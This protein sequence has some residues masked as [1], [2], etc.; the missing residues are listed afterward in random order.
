MT[1]PESA[2]YIYHNKGRFHFGHMAFYTQ[3]GSLVEI[4]YE[5]SIEDLK[6]NLLEAALGEKIHSPLEIIDSIPKDFEKTFQ[7][8]GYKSWIKFTKESASI[9]I[10]VYKN[11]SLIGIGPRGT[12]RGFIYEIQST[13]SKTIFQWLME[14][15]NLLESEEENEKAHGLSHEPEGY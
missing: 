4:G 14:H 9:S 7:K 13:D 10:R 8:A 12:K 5:G 1:I 6:L 15:L 2:L 3:Y 11:R